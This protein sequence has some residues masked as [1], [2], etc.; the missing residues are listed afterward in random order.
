MIWLQNTD[1]TLS[2]LR[3]NCGI[4]SYPTN[5]T[6]SSPYQQNLSI[7]MSLPSSAMAYAQSNPTLEPTQCSKTPKLKLLPQLR[8]P[9]SSKYISNRAETR[10]RDANP[11]QLDELELSS[12]I[13]C[14]ANGWTMATKSGST[15]PMPICWEFV[16]VRIVAVALTHVVW[17]ARAQF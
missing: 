4:K 11:S 10:Y 1:I 2:R 12:S 6:S 3:C 14:G 16:S 17:N 13:H 5:S 7:R 15:R 9:P 8:C